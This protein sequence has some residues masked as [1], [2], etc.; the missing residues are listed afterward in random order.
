MSEE[1]EKLNKMLG[2]MCE[3][4]RSLQSQMLD[5]TSK[6]T[7]ENGSPG[8]RKRKEESHD[9]HVESG[10]SEDSWKKQCKFAS[11]V[12]TVH[13]RTDPSDTTLVSPLIRPISH[14]F[15]KILSS[16]VI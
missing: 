8:S 11:K 9:N 16:Q 6:T 15:S 14:D 13:V 3:G 2:V 10:S 4:F 5:L 7:V 12:S 1:N